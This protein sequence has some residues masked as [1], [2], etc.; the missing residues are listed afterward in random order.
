MLK[1]SPKDLNGFSAGR[2][3]AF[4]VSVTDLQAPMCWYERRTDHTLAC[5]RVN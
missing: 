4:I 5:P 1:D 3:E 2:P